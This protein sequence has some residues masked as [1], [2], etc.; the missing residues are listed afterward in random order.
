MD[1][2]TGREREVISLG[3]QRIK[4]SEPLNSAVIPSDSEGS[5]LYHSW[6]GYEHRKRDPSS[7]SL[8]GMTR[9]APLLGMTISRAL[10]P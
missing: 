6:A 3:Y 8:P 1:R 10:T 9:I 5:C 4:G 7:L 2:M